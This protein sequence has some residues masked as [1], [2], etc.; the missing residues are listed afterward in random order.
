MGCTGLHMPTTGYDY[1]VCRTKTRMRFVL[2]GGRCPARYIPARPLE[3][4]VWRDLCEVLSA[5]EMV[6]HARDGAGARRA[7]AAAGDAGAPGQPAA[8]PG[9]SRP[10]SEERR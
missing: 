4:L 10:R 8:R 9:G 2:P 7:L 1:Y 5:P 6:A 3:E